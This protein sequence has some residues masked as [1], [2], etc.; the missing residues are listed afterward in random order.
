MTTDYR[1]FTPPLPHKFVV[2]G[3]F[4]LKNFPIYFRG[5]PVGEATVQLEGLYYKIVCCCQLPLGDIYRI[6]IRC[7]EDTHILGVCAPEDGRHMIRKRIPV[8]RFST[9]GLEFY[10]LDADTDMVEIS[11]NMPFYKIAQLEDA[12]FV[13]CA[14]KYYLAFSSRFSKAL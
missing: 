8:K 2:K 11:P 14:G 4:T 3:A 6:G 7:C 1:E 12:R 9:E 10:V 5:N 13:N